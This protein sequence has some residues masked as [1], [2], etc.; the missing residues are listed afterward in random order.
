VPPCRL[1]RAIASPEG[2]LGRDELSAERA[3][4]AERFLGKPTRYPLD[5]PVTKADDFV[6]NR[7]AQD[8]QRDLLAALPVSRRAPRDI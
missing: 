2:G 3:V 6:A 1:E 7:D 5:S 4:S 8:S